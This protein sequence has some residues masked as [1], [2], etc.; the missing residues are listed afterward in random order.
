MSL[1]SH[2]VACAVFVPVLGCGLHKWAFKALVVLK[3]EQTLSEA[4]TNPALRYR[5]ASSRLANATVFNISL[6][7]TVDP[8][9]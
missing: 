5:L 7:K 4:D 1:T 3:I 9:F 8:V 2:R 6:S